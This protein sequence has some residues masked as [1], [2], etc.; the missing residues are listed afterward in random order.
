MLQF[1]FLATG[2]QRSIFSTDI[3]AAEPALEHE[4]RGR[5][6]LAIGAAG[7]IG[8]STVLQLAKFGPS[9]LHLIDQN[10][11]ELAEIARQ[12]RSRPDLYAI[13]DL[14][15][16]P[17]DYGSRAL[18]LFLGSEPAYD[19]VLNFAAIKHVRSEK[20]PFSTLQ[21]F[22][23]N[24]VKQARLMSWLQEFGCRGRFFTVSTD[25]AANPSSMMGA[26]KRAMEHVLFN[27]SVARKLLAQ[28]STARFANVA[29]SNG[30]LLQSFENRLARG[31]PLAAP[32]DTKRYFV[33]LE[34]AGQ[35]CAIA[36][37]FAPDQAIVIPKLDPE[38][39]LVT[40]ESIARGF[41]AAHGYEAEVFDNEADACRSVE[42][43]RSQNRW[44]LL[45]TALDTA[46][47]KPFEEFIA[48]GEEAFDIELPNL[49]AVHYRPVDTAAIDALVDEAVTL[50][51][52]TR[53]FKTLD[54]D[55]LKGMIARVEP[56]FLNTHRDSKLSL[57][58]R[59]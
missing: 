56:E 53:P 26:T 46:G 29:F 36:S 6:I 18:Y 30:S 40:L 7:S 39:H 42:K 45:L 17:L 58:Q 11:N 34:E 21:M 27:S 16:L 37:C 25:K 33:S 22:D 23:T 31:E 5:R 28:K 49:R 32:I 12:F 52:Q 44:P 59:M 19:I 2:R 3:A 47:E 50:L 10:E 9:A 8:S 13:P 54:K 4:V 20:D 35:L 57:D 51:D 43:A 14:R 15:T 38:K 48:V 41:L 24:I 1:D 55:Y